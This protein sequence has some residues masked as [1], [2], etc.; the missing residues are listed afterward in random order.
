MKTLYYYLVFSKERPLVANIEEVTDMLI[1]TIRTRNEDL[2]L[3]L[4]ES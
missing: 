1:V 3:Y 4:A 2:S